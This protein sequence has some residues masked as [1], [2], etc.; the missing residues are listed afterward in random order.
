MKESKIY[1][2]PTATADSFQAATIYQGSGSS[3]HWNGFYVCGAG[4]AHGRTKKVVVL[5][6][7]RVLGEVA[8]KFSAVAFQ[9]DQ[10]FLKV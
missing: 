4:K 10:L 9:R 5:L 6:R 8:A 3:S 7:G 2:S 1:C